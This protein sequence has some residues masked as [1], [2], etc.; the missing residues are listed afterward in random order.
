MDERPTPPFETATT[1]APPQ[2]D[3]RGEFLPSSTKHQDFSHLHSSFRFSAEIPRAWDVEFVSQITALN[4]YDPNHPSPTAREQSQIFIRQFTADRFLTLSTVNILARE[5][6]TVHGHPSV[7]YEIEKKAGVPD[8]PHQPSWRS[9]RHKLTDVRFT[10]A[11]PSL[12]YV[13]AHRPELADD[14]VE[15]FFESLRF[16]ND[17]EGFA[18]PLPQLS[19][20]P[21]LKPFGLKISP[22]D[23]P[24]Q[25]ERFSGYHTGVDFEVFE[26]EK[27]QPVIVSAVCGGELRT[28]QRTEGY[29]GLV[30]QECLLH[31][32]PVTVI[33]GHLDLGSIQAS[34]S[35]Y[36]APGDPLGKLGEQ[37]LDTDGE[38]THLHLGIHRGS[39]VVIT[40]Y[41]DREEDLQTWID[42]MTILQR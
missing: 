35:D 28:R 7:R 29:G 16:H 20:R 27:D 9:E 4:I 39:N 42:P 15:T 11:S 3:I 14:V 8:F 30:V 32:E 36:L 13:F 41:A 19:A 10:Q 22:E 31:N 37:G 17:T 24:I 23:S 40:G 26:E 34:P 38:R 12:F 25:P 1:G 33:Y 21:I 5:E 6:T 2:G 18:A